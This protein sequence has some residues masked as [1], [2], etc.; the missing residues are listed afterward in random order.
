[1]LFVLSLLA[2]PCCAAVIFNTLSSI[3]ISSY[4]FFPLLQVVENRVVYVRPGNTS[5]CPNNV[6]Q[7]Q[8]LDWYSQNS[9]GSF[10]TDNT[11]VRFLESEHLLSTSIGKHINYH[12]LT[13]IGVGTPSHD[14]NGTPSPTSWINCTVAV[15][16]F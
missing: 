15:S 3:V 1:M 6:S 4:L 10:M 8:T 13:I 16:C 2:L 9:N 5:L 12:N 14:V 7:C 11:V